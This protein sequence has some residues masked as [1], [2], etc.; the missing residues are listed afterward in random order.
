MKLD[1]GVLV[2]VIPG[3]INLAYVMTRTRKSWS[4]FNHPSQRSYSVEYCNIIPSP[5]YTFSSFSLLSPSTL[6]VCAWLSFSHPC[7]SIT[8]NTTS[9]RVTLY[10]TGAH[11]IASP[12][13]GDTSFIMHFHPVC[14]LCPHPR[15]RTD[16]LMFSLRYQRLIL[17][18][19]A[20]AASWY[21]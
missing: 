10:T 15:Q 9:T 2:P 19:P 1:D 5:Q 4:T 6:V 7:H 13:H 11:T 12:T 20:S 3:V 16:I 17:S 14:V 21:L 8:T 18:L